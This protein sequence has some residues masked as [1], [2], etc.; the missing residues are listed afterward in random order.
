MI[1]SDR[2]IIFAMTSAP[3]ARTVANHGLPALRQRDLRHTNDQLKQRKSR[4]A[5]HATSPDRKPE[6]SVCSGQSWVGLAKLQV[7]DLERPETAR[8]A[9]EFDPSSDRARSYGHPSEFLMFERPSV[10]PAS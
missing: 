6:A 8:S 10:S 7:M 3:R 5:M 9:N 1:K 2:E 4:Q